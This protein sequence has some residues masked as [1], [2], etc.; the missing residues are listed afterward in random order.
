MTK[1]TFYRIGV[2]LWIGA[3]SVGFTGCR[4][5]AKPAGM[6]TPRIEVALPLVQPI[7]LTQEYPGYLTSEQ[8]VQLVARVNGYLKNIL[9]TP[10]SIVTK[11][12]LLFVIEPTLYEDAV[13]QAE[14]SFS[15]AQAQLDYA[16]NNYTRMKEAAASDAISEIDL[17]QSQSALTQAEAGVKN[18]Q[19]QLTTAKTNLSYCYIRAPFTGKVSRNQFDVGAYISG[20]GQPAELASLYND[21]KMYAYFDVED[22]Q[23][24]KMLMQNS[25][26]K[27]SDLAGDVSIHFSEALFKTY[28]GKLNYM[29]P[30]VNLSTG[31]ISL[32]AE[33]DN[34]TG[35]LKSGLYVTVRLPYGERNEAI[36]I[37]NASIGTDQLGNY[38]YAVNDSNR[39]V[40]RHVALG[41]LVNDTLREIT[42]GLSPKDMYVTKALLKV[43]NGMEIEPIKTNN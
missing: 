10:G 16:R 21:V 5:K 22:N 7:V 32:R 26:T 18:A 31:T 23:Y 24:L 34:P 4:E 38:V 14:A 27:L 40:Y 37:N 15:S 1:H 35:E 28:K 30:N 25:S 29:A 9:Y 11:D 39:V 3:F 12:K 13:K 43:R 8:S 6:P 20:A 17:I 33:I 41:E 36:L 19:A 2:L 42:S